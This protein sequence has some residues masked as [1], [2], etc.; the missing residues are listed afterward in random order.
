MALKINKL[1]I[2]TKDKKGH[3]HHF[4]S[5]KA[6]MHLDIVLEHDIDLDVHTILEKGFIHD[7]HRFTAN[8]DV[9]GDAVR[10]AHNKRRGGKSET[11]EV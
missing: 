5:S 7:G 9:R 8:Y 6:S 4:V 10:K 11:P 3:L 1:Y 2:V